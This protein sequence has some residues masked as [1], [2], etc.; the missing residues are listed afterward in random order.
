M[1]P[2]PIPPPPNKCQTNFDITVN[3][4]KLMNW[5]YCFKKNWLSSDHLQDWNSGKPLLETDLDWFRT[6]QFLGCYYVT[7]IVFF[8]KKSASVTQFHKSKLFFVNLWSKSFFWI[9]EFPKNSWK[10]MKSSKIIYL[11]SIIKSHFLRN[12]GRV[13]KWCLQIF[14]VFSYFVLNDD[15]W[16]MVNFFPKIPT[17]LAL[18][19]QKVTHWMKLLLWKQIYV[20]RTLLKHFF[21]FFSFSENMGWIIQEKV[22]FHLLMLVVV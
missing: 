14:F 5:M 13:W 8:I 11:N 22:N 20:S 12:R 3:I 15:I 2:S 1:P 16:H 9:T 18:L 21:F 19:G 6:L 4:V 7:S 17:C 10:L